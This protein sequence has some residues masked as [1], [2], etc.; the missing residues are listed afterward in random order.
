LLLPAKNN[1]GSDEDGFAYRLEG[2]PTPNVEWEP[3]PVVMTADE[4]VGVEHHARGP[5]PDARHDAEAWL[6]D[7]LAAGP[8][9]AQEVYDAAARDGHTKATIRRAKAA[10]SIVATKDGYQG[11]WTW[12][13]PGSGPLMAVSEPAAIKGASKGAQGGLSQE[14]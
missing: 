1:L 10:L 13:L 2:E 7:F 9:P 5:E 8:Q 3:M 6:L 14:T 12:T 4:A 11:A